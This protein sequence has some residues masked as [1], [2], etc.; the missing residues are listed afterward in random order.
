M[1]RQIAN[2][3]Y[4]RLIWKKKSLAK[5]YSYL[6]LIHN[7]VHNAC[8]VPLVVFCLVFW[9]TVRYALEWMLRCPPYSVRLSTGR[10]PAASDL[11]PTRL[12]LPPA[13]EPGSLRVPRSPVSPGLRP[14][15]YVGPV[16]CQEPSV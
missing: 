7:T 4:V 2:N 5:H 12:L 10:L 11:L 6:D 16:G 9:L 15:Q 3:R 1:D 13:G 8:V 14:P